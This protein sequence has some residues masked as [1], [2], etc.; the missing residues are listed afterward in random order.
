MTAVIFASGATGYDSLFAQLLTA[1]SGPSRQAW[2]GHYQ[3]IPTV[4]K[5]GRG[6]EE[7]RSRRVSTV[8]LYNGLPPCL[9]SAL[10]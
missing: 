1:G 3:I 8:G 2:D 9:L 5:W 6:R 4:D 10:I 7:P